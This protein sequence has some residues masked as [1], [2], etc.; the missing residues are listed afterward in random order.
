MEQ[1][2]LFGRAWCPLEDM[3][4]DEWRTLLFDR[5][6]QVNRLMLCAVY[7]AAVYCVAVYC[8]LLLSLS[9]SHTHTHTHTPSLSLSLSPLSIASRLPQHFVPAAF[10][11]INHLP[12]VGLAKV[13]DR[14][15]LPDITA[16]LDEV[17]RLF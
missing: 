1:A 6:P 16:A 13:L 11:Y 14:S 7:C 9:L 12:R 10:Y 3:R 17:N 8:V 4:Q 5:L 2:P 15:L